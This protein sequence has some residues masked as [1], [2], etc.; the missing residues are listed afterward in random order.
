MNIDDLEWQRERYGG[1]RPR[2]VAE[3]L[4]RGGQERR[5]RSAAWGWA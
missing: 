4:E 5:S 1:V 3:V 2:I